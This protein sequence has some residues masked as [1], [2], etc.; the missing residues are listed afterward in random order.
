MKEL[1]ACKYA[2]II[3]N[4]DILSVIGSIFWGWTEPD[5]FD[6]LNKDS[7][8][9]LAPMP[10][11]ELPKGIAPKETFEEICLN[12]AKE[13]ID[14]NSDKEIVL[15]WSGG[16]DSTAIICSL[17]M[18]GIS[19]SQLTIIYT[20]ESIE[21]N[22]NFYQWLLNNNYR[23]IKYN[24]I[25][26]REI[27][28]KFPYA[29][30]TTGWCADQLFGSNVNQAYPHL[31]TVD[32]KDGFKEILNDRYFSKNLSISEIDN[33]ISKF[34][35]YAEQIGMPI[36]YT[37]DALWLFNFC[38]KWSHVR[39][40]LNLTLRTDDQR[41]RSF[42]FFEDM[43]F[44]EWSIA[45]YHNLYKHNQSTDVEYYKKPLKD[46]IYSFNHDEEYYKNKGKVN[47]WKSTGKLGVYSTFC[48]HDEEGYHEY[49]LT[50]DTPASK[51]IL[52]TGHKM[53]LNKRWYLKD[54]LKDWVDKE[55]FLKDYT[56]WG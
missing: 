20:P 23:M 48:I 3:E 33:C 6:I 22:K 9:N 7:P 13:F 30:F 26:T 36:K 21:E 46:L 1:I 42:C 24:W 47:S 35:E 49:D 19:K 37:C 2:P 11:K 40:D 27:V 32:Y 12:V 55:K 28:E 16:V 15:F 31:Y 54:Y 51:N 14:K 39:D 4:N 44:Q 53:E 10:N 43:R 34:G 18:A 38:V 5:R 29:V 45:N 17:I 52:H 56:I 25:A 41:S 50:M 8:Y